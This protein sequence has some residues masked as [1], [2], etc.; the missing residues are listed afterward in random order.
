[1]RKFFGPAVLLALGVIALPAFAQ[2]T[3]TPATKAKEAQAQ[4]VE[5][6]EERREERRA[7]ANKT[8]ENRA[9]ARATHTPRGNA[10]E[11]LA[12]VMHSGCRNEMEIAKFA[13]PKLNSDAAKQFAERI[14][15]EHQ[16]EG[17]KLDKLAGQYHPGEAATTFEPHAKLEFGRLKLE[18]G[19]STV[20]AGGEGNPHVNAHLDWVDIQQQIAN[21][22]LA[23][24]KAELQ[25]Y[26]G[27]HFDE[28][29]M[30]MQIASHLKIVDQ[31]KVFQN[32]ASS[33][34]RSQID[35]ALQTAENHLK[36][37]RDIVRAQARAVD[38][39]SAK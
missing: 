6:R 24:A 21:Q 19:G 14:I 25:Q 38:R 27:K 39:E 17:E 23:S 29:F 7:E 37:A 34:F 16:A 13:L 2:E 22:C 33:N 32:Y 18:A 5:R 1:M 36:E 15:K 3:T 31:L 20:R 4:R 10:D 28:A 30:G 9:E 8:A 26:E 11:Q 12:A 35:S